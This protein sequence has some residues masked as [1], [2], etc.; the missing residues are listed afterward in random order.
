MSHQKCDCNRG[1]LLNR[2]SPSDLGA[3]SMGAVW[4]DKPS[5]ATDVHAPKHKDRVLVGVGR[6]ASNDKIHYVGQDWLRLARPREADDRES[7]ATEF[8]TLKEFLS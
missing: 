3:Y 8:P 7:Y 4:S 6:G 1:L 2:T 5:T